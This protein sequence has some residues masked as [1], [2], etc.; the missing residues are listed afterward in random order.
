MTC[1]PI[2]WESMI[3]W[4]NCL[5]IYIGKCYQQKILYTLKTAAMTWESRRISPNS[6]HCIHFIG[7][8]LK[9][10][11]IHHRSGLSQKFSWWSPF[12]CKEVPEKHLGGSR[13]F[14]CLCDTQDIEEMWETPS[15]MESSSHFSSGPIFFLLIIS[16]CILAPPP[17]FTLITA[18]Q[19]EDSHSGKVK[20]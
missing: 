15:S 2:L 10:W 1:F 8:L 18:G 17:P 14:S 3:Y 19:N 9:F 7:W 20:E 12:Y 4:T 13:L 5:H 16:S 11:Y 6:W